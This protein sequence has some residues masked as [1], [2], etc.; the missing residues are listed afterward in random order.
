[1]KRSRRLVVCAGCALALGGCA[2]GT[3]GG[4]GQGPGSPSPVDPTEVGVSGLPSADSAAVVA[5]I[6]SRLRASAE[7]WNRG[8]LEAFL[9]DYSDDPGLA[10]VGSSDVVRGK[11]AVRGRYRASYFGG[12]GEP[13]DL[14]FEQLQVRLRAAE[15]AVAHGRWTLFQPGF[16]VQTVTAQGRFTLVFRR[17]ADG[18]WRIIHDHAS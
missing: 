14:A 18:R 2:A 12:K 8:D 3:G 7:A 9:E 4:A 17:E 6:T 16:E 13:D 11:D 15:V 10:F 5:E 1:M